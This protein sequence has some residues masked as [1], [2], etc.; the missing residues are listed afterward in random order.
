M[1]KKGDSVPHRTTTWHRSLCRKRRTTMEF[2][3]NQLGKAGR[4]SFIRVDWKSGR[5][6][7][8]MPPGVSGAEATATGGVDF[9][10]PE[11]KAKKPAAAP[12]A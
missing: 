6:G 2:D 4:R 5:S 8:D 12:K 7:I 11:G 1:L 10:L 9:V 3:V